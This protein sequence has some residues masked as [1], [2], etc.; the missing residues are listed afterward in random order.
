MIKSIYGGN[1]MKKCFKCG[2]LI[3]DDS[4]FCPY[5]G[6]NLNSSTLSNDNESECLNCG[7]R[8]KPHQKYCPNCGYDNPNYDENASAPAYDNDTRN[9]EYRNDYR[10]EKTT[11][12]PVTMF[13]AYG[14]MFKNAFNFLGRAS[15]SEFWWVVLMNIIIGFVISIFDTITGLYYVYEYEGSLFQIGYIDIIYRL[16]TIIPS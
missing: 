12:E 4:S 1:F 13:K 8:L 14:L 15:R 11:K 5:C 2:A 9:N 10:E 16:I 6:T 7:F 3:D